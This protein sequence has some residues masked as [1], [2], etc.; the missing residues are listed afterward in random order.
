MKKKLL[1]LLL[2]VPILL[3]PILSCDGL[4]SLSDLMGSLGA[5]NGSV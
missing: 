5:L 2:I 1:V 4:E 3:I